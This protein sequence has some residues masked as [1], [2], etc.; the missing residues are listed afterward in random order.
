MVRLQ[1]G[2]RTPTQMGVQGGFLVVRPNQTD[3][4]R[5]VELLRSGGDYLKGA[6]WGG[7]QKLYGGY[8]GSGTIQGLASYYYAEISKN[9]SVEMNRC[10]Y[11]QMVDPP[12][13]KPPRNSTCRTLEKSCQDCRTTPIEEIYST[14][15]T[16]CGKPFW[17]PNPA[18]WWDVSPAMAGGE[19]HALCMDLL[20]EW[21]LVRR[22]LE[23]EWKQKFSSFYPKYASP[24]DT[25]LTIGYYLNYSQGHCRA[26]R[27]YIP[28]QFPGVFN[29]TWIP[30][31]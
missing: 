10:Y 20:R 24:P 22:S 28:M 31:G 26:P 7:E 18:Q 5:N 14:H 16:N 13:G 23:T 9:R 2:H 12:Y 29:E 3:F 4:D 19:H 27:E 11:N 25:N 1:P 17:C 6:G 8:Y 15:F 30:K 21:H